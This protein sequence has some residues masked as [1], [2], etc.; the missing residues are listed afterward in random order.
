M[1]RDFLTVG[2]LSSALFFLGLNPA[3]ALPDQYEPDNVQANATAIQAGVSASH[4]IFPNDDVDWFKITLNQIE[5]IQIKTTGPTNGGIHM[6]LF[7]SN[8]TVLKDDG[9]FGHP[10]IKMNALPVGTYFVKISHYPGDGDVSLYNVV[11]ST[12]VDDGDRFEPNNVDTNAVTIQSGITT[13]LNIIPENDTDWVKFTASTLSNLELEVTGPTTGMAITLYDSNLTKL[14]DDRTPG[15]PKITHNGLPPGTY[16]AKF[17]TYPSNHG[18]ID[19]YNI[20]LNL[21]AGASV[22]DIDGNGDV[23]ALTDGLL[24]LRHSFGFSG[25][26][27]INNAI[28]TGA[29]RQSAD[30]IKAYL[31][32]K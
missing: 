18:P 11:Y 31:D 28:G 32:S 26:A 30:D 24:I 27:L 13:N 5:T 21:H 7:D 9:N 2:L 14:D 12:T 8:L 20:N 25:D 3:Y 4:T 23:E 6:T 19:R 10:N 15:Y 29:T 17:E 16:F 1:K 22:F